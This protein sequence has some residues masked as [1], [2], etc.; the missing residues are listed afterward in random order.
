MPTKRSAKLLQRQ[1]NSDKR[2]AIEKHG[3]RLGTFTS[4]FRVSTSCNNTHANMNETR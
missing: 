2:Q 4:S 1:D 3:H